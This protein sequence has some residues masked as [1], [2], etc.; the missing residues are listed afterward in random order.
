MSHHDIFENRKQF[1]LERLILFSDAV[2]AIVITLLVLEIKIPSSNWAKPITQDK[3]N[4]YLLELLPNLSGFIFSFFIVGFYWTI[5]HRMFGYVTSFDAKVI[6]LNLLMLFFIALLPFTTT[7]TSEYGYLVKSFMFYWIN[8]GLIG[9]ISFFIQ[10]H[11]S[12]P[13][14]NLSV[15]YEDKTLRRFALSRS[16]LTS[17]IFFTG[18][19]MCLSANPYLQLLARFI[20]IFI[21]PCIIILKRV[22]HVKKMK[23]AKPVSQ[24]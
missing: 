10:L 12:N 15:G 8:V 21:F 11:V 22:F 19:A 5:H 18:A 24:T 1:Q 14:K 20:Y 16:L 3:L 23:P 4:E 13:N 9:L 6:W 7:L 17:V 2:F